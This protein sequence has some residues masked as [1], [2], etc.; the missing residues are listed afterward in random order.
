MHNLKSIN[1]S[2]GFLGVGAAVIADIGA[3][4]GMHLDGKTLAIHAAIVFCATLG[5]FLQDARKNL[6]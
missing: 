4:L 3:S 6:D 5:A 2:K 1:W